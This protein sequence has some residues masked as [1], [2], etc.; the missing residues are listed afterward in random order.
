MTHSPVS[1]N[2]LPLLVLLNTKCRFLVEVVGRGKFCCSKQRPREVVDSLC[3]AGCWKHDFSLDRYLVCGSDCDVGVGSNKFSGRFLWYALR[4]REY[5]SMTFLSRLYQGK[6]H[7]T[8]PV[9]ALNSDPYR[10][11]M[12]LFTTVDIGI[13]MNR[14]NSSSPL[15]ML[16]CL[17][18]A[19]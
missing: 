7:V 13:T 14:Y 5:S 4:I 9:D 12:T 2:Y 19:T 3:I 6:L 11:T 16:I 15:R 8:F 10:S 17:P 18:I 1:K